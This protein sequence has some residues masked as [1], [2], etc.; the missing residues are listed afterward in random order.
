M[1]LECAFAS[2]HLLEPIVLMG[3]VHCR[4]RIM[5]SATMRVERVLV[6]HRGYHL[7]ATQPPVLP[8][9]LDLEVAIN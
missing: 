9:V 1:T 8:I 7:L 4:V 3:C 5:E 6:R 2:R